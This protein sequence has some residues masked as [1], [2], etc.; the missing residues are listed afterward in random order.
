MP[1][2]AKVGGHDEIVT[3]DEGVLIPHG[4]NELR[5]YVDAIYRLLSNPAES[6]QMSKKCKSLA[7]SKLSWDGMIDNFLAFL[8]EAH[9]LRVNHPRY[10]ISP[11]FGRELASL[12]LECKRLGEAVDWLWHTKPH[13]A[14][15]DTALLTTSP[16]AQAVAKYAILSSQTWLGRT[17]IHN[18]FL[19]AIGKRILKLI[20][21]RG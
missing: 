11:N 6:K 19:K 20:G 5:E 10:P 7:A 3:P 8:D 16:E 9:H 21:A 14:T 2:V 18:R 17:I 4:E 12:S 13:S 15:T 1:V